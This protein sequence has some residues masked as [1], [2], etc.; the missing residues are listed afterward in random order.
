MKFL[1][2]DRALCLSP[3]P[4]DVE[5][6]MSGT[7][8]RFRDT[9]FAVLLMSL[10]NK[11]DPTSGPKRLEEADKFWKDIPNVRFQDRLIWPTDWSMEEWVHALAEREYD[12]I[13]VPTYEDSH[14]NHRFAHQ[15][16]R[17]L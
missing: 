11:G 14:Q 15:L 1:G 3:H 7:I 10:G 13:F 8:R 6:G 16:G 9:H 12:A 2:L 17:S 5:Y 4:D